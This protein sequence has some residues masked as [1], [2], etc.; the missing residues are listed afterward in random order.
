MVQH[1]MQP[2]DLW[3]AKGRKGGWQPEHVHTLCQGKGAG[4]R[5][6]AGVQWQQLASHGGAPVQK[7]K[8]RGHGARREPA[9]NPAGSR[10]VPEGGKPWQEGGLWGSKTW[11]AACPHS[12]ES[13]S[14][15]A[16]E[17]QGRAELGAR[18][19]LGEAGVPAAPAQGPS[20]A[21]RHRGQTGSRREEAGEQHPRR[22]GTAPY[23]TARP[24]RPERLPTAVRD[25]RGE[26][27]GRPAA[28][29]LTL[30]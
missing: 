12:R 7:G 13:P 19:A 25:T 24:G 1:C 29:P 14:G 23:G 11:Q 30:R 27:R 8:R 28:A 22:H 10:P 9:A 17:R 6:R 26:D 21:H 3:G 16:G 15:D 5:L 20:V 18:W 2:C 4:T